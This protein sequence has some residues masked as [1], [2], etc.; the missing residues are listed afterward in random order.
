MPV[1]RSCPIFK[2]A[3]EGEVKHMRVLLADDQSQVRSALRVL[4]EYGTKWRVI[5]EASE[6]EELVARAKADHPDLVLL[7]WELPGLEPTHALRALRQLCP[8]LRIIVLSSQPEARQDALATGADGFVS[9]GD[10][11]ERLLAVMSAGFL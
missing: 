2:I 8:Q 3:I 9:K 10:P 11:P 5:G 1:A 6:A 4:L 7:D